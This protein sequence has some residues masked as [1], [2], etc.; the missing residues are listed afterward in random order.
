MVHLD[1]MQS[2]IKFQS[3]SVSCISKSQICHKNQREIL[4]GYSYVL[5]SLPFRAPLTVTLWWALSKKL[6]SGE[7]CDIWREA[8][9]TVFAQHGCL[10]Q[11]KVS[12]LQFNE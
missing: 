9:S 8:F 6:S 5:L 2:F 3:Q 1:T 10:A 4:S 11:S 12:K 7:S